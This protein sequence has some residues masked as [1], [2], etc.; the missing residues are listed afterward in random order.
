[1][2]KWIV[3]ININPLSPNTGPGLEEIIDLSV[4]FFKS[5][6]DVFVVW[7][8]LAVLASKLTAKG[9]VV[10]FSNLLSVK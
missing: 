6:N 8:N 9:V 1:M 4:C 2:T 5:R 10:F 7:I 3:L